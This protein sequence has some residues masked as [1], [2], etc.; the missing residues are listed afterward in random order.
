VKVNGTD[1]MDGQNAR[2]AAG[3][4][5]VGGDCGDAES[6]AVF[7]TRRSVGK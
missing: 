7:L 2:G 3:R 4:W 6:G 5:A 1:P